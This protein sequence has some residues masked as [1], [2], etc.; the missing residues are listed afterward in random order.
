MRSIASTVKRRRVPGPVFKAVR[1]STG[2]DMQ[3]LAELF[4]IRCAWFNEEEYL[5]VLSPH[6]P[7]AAVN[8]LSNAPTAKAR[9]QKSRVFAML[10]NHVSQALRASRRA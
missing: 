4:D 7:H 6:A 8:D 3:H 2:D 1:A 9:T 10:A 5:K